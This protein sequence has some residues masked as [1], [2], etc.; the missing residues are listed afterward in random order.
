MCRNPIP[1]RSN[2]AAAKNKWHRLYQL[3]LHV[4]HLP[5]K[6]SKLIAFTSYLDVEFAHAGLLFPS[7]PSQS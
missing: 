7:D 6:S 4:D 2:R 5:L 1:I 3:L